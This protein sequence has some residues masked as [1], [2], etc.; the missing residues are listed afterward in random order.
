MKPTQALPRWLLPPGLHDP[1][2]RLGATLRLGAA[3]RDALR[4]NRS[5][6]GRHAGRRGF[7]LCSGPSIKTQDLK[8][9]RGETCIGVSNFF[10]H[11]D[12]AAINPGYHCVAPLHPPFTEADGVRWF[13]EMEPVLAG[14]ELFLGHTDR[15]LVETHRLFAQTRV[16]Y[17]AYAGFSWSHPG[18]HP[19]DLDRI[20]PPAQSVSIM[21]LQV[22]LGLG[23]SEIY[24]L[25]ADHTSINFQ[26]G[27]YNYQHFYTG[28]RANALGEDT[29][30]TDLGPIFDSYAEL[31]RQYRALRALAARRGVR[32]FNATRGGL[33]DLFPRVELEAVC[34][35]A[36]AAA[37]KASPSP[38]PH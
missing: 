38:L 35:G 25:G 20:L 8:L 6:A 14:R 15:A 23:F 21:A 5:L 17:L 33:L 10:V 27:Q 22:A 4:A 31:W 11:P 36:P 9:L 32:I 19:I 16:H 24:L 26:T 1:L 18:G 30:P 37:E 34:L 2:R 12:Y 28:Q 3:G 7:I 13:R 29:P